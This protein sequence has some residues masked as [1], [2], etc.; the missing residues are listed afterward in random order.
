MN[1]S[2]TEL[3][4]FGLKAIKSGYRDE[5]EEMSEKNVEVSVIENGLFRSLS[6][7]EIK[8]HLDNLNEGMIIEW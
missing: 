2:L 4:Q 8:K 7:T 5:K 6:Q 1:S 3:V